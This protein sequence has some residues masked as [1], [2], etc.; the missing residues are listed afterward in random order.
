MSQ[1]VTVTA[2]QCLESRPSRQASSLECLSLKSSQSIETK[3]VEH[4]PIELE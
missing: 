3:I 1:I 4:S 2:Y